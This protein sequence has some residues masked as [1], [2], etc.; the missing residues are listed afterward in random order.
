MAKVKMDIFKTLYF[1]SSQ[2]LAAVR[3]PFYPLD[4][5]F[6]VSCSMPL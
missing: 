3:R 2:S 5:N 6:F 1:Q 4:K